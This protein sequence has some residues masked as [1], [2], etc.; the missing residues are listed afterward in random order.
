MDNLTESNSNDHKDVALQTDDTNHPQIETATLMLEPTNANLII[1]T[2]RFII[3]F[4]LVLVIGLSGATMLTT[5]YLNKYYLPGWLL[6]GY[7]IANLGGW[8]SVSICTRSS[9]VRLGSAFGCLWAIMMGFI[10]A[11]NLFPHTI[12]AQATFL[13][14]ASASASSALLACSI[15]L[16]TAWTPLKRWDRIFFL[17]APIIGIIFVAIFFLYTP[18]TM[19]SSLLLELYIA[20]VELWLCTAIWWLRPSCWRTQPGPAF[21][22]G[23]VPVIQ[24]LLLQPLNT[25]NESIVFFSQVMLLSVLLGSLRILQAEIRHRLPRTSH[26]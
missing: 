19:R 2:P 26:L 15:C 21:L 12:D 11:L 13:V 22:L 17:T 1:W 6:I 25:Y 8:I 5:G 23:V 3:S 16:S 18:V 9:W 24:I 20:T 7:S 4:F 10:F 14:N